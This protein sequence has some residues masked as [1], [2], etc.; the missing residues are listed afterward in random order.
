MIKGGSNK[1]LERDSYTHSHENW[2]TS[3]SYE[4]WIT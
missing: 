2:K 3:K 1:E 4:T